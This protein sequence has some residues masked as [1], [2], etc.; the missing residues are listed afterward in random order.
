MEKL[1]SH[2]RW[3]GVNDTITDF[4]QW[5]RTWRKM[6]A[7]L[8]RSPRRTVRGLKTYGLTEAFLSVP[9]TVDSYTGSASGAQLREKHGD[10]SEYI[11][12]C[13]DCASAVFHASEKTVYTQGECAES[14]LR[15]FPGLK[16]V[17]V[18]TALLLFGGEGK[19]LPSF[20]GCGVLCSPS[21]E[22]YVPP[23]V[24]ILKNGS[25]T[26]IECIRFVEKHTGEKFDWDIFTETVSALSGEKRKSPAEAVRL[27]AGR[28]L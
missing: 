10:I 18:S 12:G 1:P 5:L 8:L 13:F 23:P 22:K 11:Q 25:E 16:P 24:Y 6:L 17:S 9:A 21:S 3:R 27:L 7:F 19:T 14:I 4:I 2:R 20:G 15:G 26:I 28:V